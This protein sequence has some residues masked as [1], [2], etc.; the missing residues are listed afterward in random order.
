MIRVDGGMVANNW[1]LG[2]LAD[3]LSVPVERPK[4]TEST[5]LGAAWLAGL[6]S[7]VYES[8]DAIANLWARDAVFNP[9]MMEDQRKGL[10]LGWQAAVSRIRSQV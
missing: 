8:I 1:F 2:F 6:Q 3:I 10:Y 7:G 9:S 4:N 5:V